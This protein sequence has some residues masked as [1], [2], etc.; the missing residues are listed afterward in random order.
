MFACDFEYDGRLLSD[1]GFIIC[2]FD[3]AGG[4]ETEDTGYQITFDKVS[5]S[6]GMRNSLIGTKYESCVTTTFQ[7][8]KNEDDVDDMEISTEEYRELVRWL[9]RHE[10]LPFRTINGADT[11]PDSTTCYFDGSFNI[12]K[13]YMADRLFGLELT[14]ETNAPYGYGIPFEQTWNVSAGGTI[15]FTD[16]SDE[17]RSIRPDLTIVCRAS[18]NLVITNSTTLCSMEINNCTNGETITVNGDAQ[19]IS[20]SLATHKIFND[21]NYDFLTIGNTFDSGVN[22]LTFS[23]PC[24]FTLRYKPIIKDIP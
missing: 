24:A 11:E 14:L 5:R 4:I 19:I 2:H 16:N 20:T 13:I 8:C 17:S 1:F 22:T 3:G 7:I 15:T 6:R 10:F 23:L 12:K 9:N 21:F 18:G